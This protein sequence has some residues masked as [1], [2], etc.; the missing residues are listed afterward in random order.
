L[1]KREHPGMVAEVFAN[2]NAGQESLGDFSAIV[3]ADSV[4]SRS[5]D[6]SDGAS[7]FATSSES[8]PPTALAA[9]FTIERSSSTE[10]VIVQSCWELVLKS[11]TQ[12][13]VN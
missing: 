3:L 5:N 1:L 8:S 13:E 6:V 9:A 7:P 11:F 12:Y 10:I 4:A 2:V